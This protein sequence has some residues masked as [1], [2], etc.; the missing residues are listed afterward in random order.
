MYNTVLFLVQEKFE[1]MNHKVSRNFLPMINPCH[2][3][4]QAGSEI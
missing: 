1:D 3:R 4:G 2:A